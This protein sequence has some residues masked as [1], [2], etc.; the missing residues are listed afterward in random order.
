VIARRNEDLKTGVNA[1]VAACGVKPFAEDVEVLAK[2]RVAEALNATKRVRER[3]PDGDII[4]VDIPDHPIRAAVGIKIVEHNLG[5]PVTRAIHAHLTQPGS[6]AEADAG[7]TLLQLLLAAPDAAASIVEKLQIAA[8][9]A[10]KAE[11]VEIEGA[12]RLPE[13]PKA[14]A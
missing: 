7:D 6:K 9:K 3:N 4:Y 13:E 8:Q 14:G 2:Q 1:M 10:K 12:P 11:P 5:K